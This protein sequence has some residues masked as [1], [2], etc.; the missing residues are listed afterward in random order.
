MR[1]IL[2]IDIEEYFHVEAVAGRIPPAEW[3]RCETRLAP[4][5]D[6]LLEM[7]HAHQA[8]ATFFVLGWV[9]R[10]ESDVVRRIAACG[11]ELACHGMDHRRIDRLTPDELRRDVSDGRKILEDLAGRPVLGYRAPTFSVTR[12]TA[13]ALDVLME[14]GFQYDASVFPVYHDRYG[15]PDAPRFVHWAVGPGGGRILEIPPLTWRVAGLNLPVGGG[16]YLRLFPTR[17]VFAGLEQAR[18]AGQ[19][20]MIYV[21]PWE[22]DPEQPEL[23]L[24]RIAR[25][26]HRVG[27]AAMP[28]K[29]D[30]LLGRYRFASASEVLSPIRTNVADQFSYTDGAETRT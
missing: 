21:H 25:W 27:M 15:V 17:M 12:A 14:A 20:G 11:H 6:R 9:A 3:L 23:P 30:R 8:T 16:G 29:L 26:R 22:L 19:P 7:L 1:H 10:H 28:R 13:W 18:A 2:S 4:C 5:V 24:G